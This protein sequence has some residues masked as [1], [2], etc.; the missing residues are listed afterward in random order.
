MFI[1]FDFAA[2]AANCIFDSNY[3]ET[4][5]SAQLDAALEDYVERLDTAL[6][7]H[8]LS[9]SE[10]RFPPHDQW[11]ASEGIGRCRFGASLV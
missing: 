5:S 3:A 2:F 11:R 6:T 7:K 4:A 1:A 8:A 9:F 10:G